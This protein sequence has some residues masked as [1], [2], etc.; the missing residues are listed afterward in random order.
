M[1]GQLRVGPKTNNQADWRAQ[2]KQPNRLDWDLFKKTLAR[3]QKQQTN[4][5]YNAKLIKYSPF[6]TKSALNQFGTVFANFVLFF[7]L[8]KV[9][10]PQIAIWYVL[11]GP[12]ISVGRRIITLTD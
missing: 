6:I 8:A 11:G 1:P 12:P 5:K 7:C 3:P 2:N 9:V 4:S 10:F